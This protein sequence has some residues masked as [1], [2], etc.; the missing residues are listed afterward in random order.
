MKRKLIVAAVAA[1]F[2][3]AAWAQMGPGYGGHMGPG[4]MWGQGPAASSDDDAYCGYGPGAGMMGGYSRGPGAG[5]MGGYY[6]RGNYDALKLT[7]AQREKIA[8]IQKDASNKQWATM[9]AMHDLR[10]S[11]FGPDATK[12]ADPRQTYEA[13]AALR[14]Q[15]FDARVDAQERI[16]GVL[17]AEQKDQL[18]NSWRP[19][20]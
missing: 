15:M 14:K 13:M 10:W 9:K 16:D 4:M 20:G 3:A 6:G 11:A 12:K 7:D 1:L 18:R 5:M 17:T 8:A 19:R 2:S